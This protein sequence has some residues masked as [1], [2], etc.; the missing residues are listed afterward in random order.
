MATDSQTSP[1]RA[2]IGSAGGIR[3]DSRQSQVRPPTQRRVR[4]DWRQLRGRAGASLRPPLRS[5]TGDRSRP[6]APPTPTW[7]PPLPDGPLPAQPLGRRA[8]KVGR[9]DGSGDGEKAAGASGYSPATA[10]LDVYCNPNVHT[11]HATTNIWF[12]LNRYPDGSYVAIQYAYARIGVE[13][14][15]ALYLKSDWAY[16]PDGEY[17][18]PQRLYPN[19]RNERTSPVGWSALVYDATPV[20]RTTFTGSYGYFVIYVTVA[21]WNDYYDYWEFGPWYYARNYSNGPSAL[22]LIDSYGNFCQGS[23][24]G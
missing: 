14:S 21:V 16:Y 23:W 11:M 24:N 19:I 10:D 6:G 15:G 9:L 3:V 7:S 1:V 5:P 20:N 8:G 2:P 22:G 17:T 13:L 18:T 12:D 4:I